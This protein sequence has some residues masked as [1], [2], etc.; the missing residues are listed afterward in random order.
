MR[1]VGVDDVPPA[2]TWQEVIAVWNGEIADTDVTR[3]PVLEVV[4]ARTI[5]E[6]AVP[7]E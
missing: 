6:P 7:Y 5:D 4:S 3:L 2:D 1:L